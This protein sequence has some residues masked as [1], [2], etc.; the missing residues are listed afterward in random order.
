[1]NIF[2]LDSD[3]RKSAKYHTDKHCVKM[4]LEHCQML[5]TALNINSYLQQ[6]IA[7]V[8]IAY[9]TPISR[10]RYHVGCNSIYGNACRWI[11]KN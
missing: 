11:I 2:I 8:D 7:V 6:D 4:I 5:C 1:M 9:K 3:I 10:E